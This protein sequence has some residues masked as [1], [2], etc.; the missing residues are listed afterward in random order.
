MLAH[1]PTD[2]VYVFWIKTIAGFTADGVGTALP[3]DDTTWAANGYVVVPTTVGGT[4][5]STI[6]LRR[7]VA[8]VECRAVIPGSGLPPWGKAADLAEQ[9]RF[10]TYD[11][12][13][14]GRSL[15]ITLNGA[16]YPDAKVLS[17]KILTEPRRI[18]ADAADYAGYQFDLALQWVQAGEVVQ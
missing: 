5:H 1:T 18:Y 15:P 11:R 9:I 17:A 12:R 2:L 6:P 7:P 13:N 8:Q 10:A 3:P 16:V 4:P 14:F